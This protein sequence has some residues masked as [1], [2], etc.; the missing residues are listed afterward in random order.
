MTTYITYIKGQ[1]SRPADASG[2]Q[3]FFDRDPVE[4]DPKINCL[5]PSGPP[6]GRSV[7]FDRVAED[8]RP[9]DLRNFYPKGAPEGA[10]HFHQ[11]YVPTSYALMEVG[12]VK[13][14]SIKSP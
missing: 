6:N 9:P 7:F 3:V 5:W 10:T 8:L 11:R 13:A 12:R 4:E 14:S 2:N 1:V